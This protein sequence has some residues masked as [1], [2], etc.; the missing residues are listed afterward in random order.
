MKTSEHTQYSISFLFLELVF[1]IVRF[2]AWWYSRG[3]ANVGRYWARHIRIV[4]ERLSLR[5]WFRNMFTPM[6]GDYTRSGRIISFFLRIVI[7]IWR[8][9]ELIVSAVFFGVLLVIWIGLPPAV[10]Y[11]IVRQFR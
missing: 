6:Y 10:T 7:L 5:I 8:L 3:L 2:P 11:A 4:S 9:I 1:D